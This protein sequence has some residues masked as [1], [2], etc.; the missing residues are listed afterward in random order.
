MAFGT[1]NTVNEPDSKSV[2]QQGDKKQNNSEVDL[3]EELE[4]GTENQQIQSVDSTEDD[5]VSKYN[6]IFYFL[7]KMKYNESEEI[8][9]I[10]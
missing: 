3:T 2:Q 5:S 7:Y 10:F 1:G 4:G 9:E 8:E 6:F